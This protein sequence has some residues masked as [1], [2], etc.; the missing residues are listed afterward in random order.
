M[1]EIILAHFNIVNNGYQQD[2]TVF[3]TF[4]SNKYFGQLSDILPKNYTFL[5]TFD[6]EFS[7]VEIWFKAQNSEQ[8]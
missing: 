2:S 1:N 6:L 5:R 7:N 8:L 4:V 3:Y